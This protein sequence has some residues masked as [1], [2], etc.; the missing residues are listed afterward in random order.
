MQ[1]FPGATLGNMTQDVRNLPDALSQSCDRLP[2]SLFLC[3]G[4]GSI[5]DVNET[6]CR[7]L[8]FSRADLRRLGV[9]DLD[10]RFSRA[11]WAELSRTVRPG[12]S[13]RFGAVLRGRG[14]VTTKV[15]LSMT[16]LE[17]GGKV[18]YLLMADHRAPAQE[19][20]LFS[21]MDAARSDGERGGRYCSWAVDLFSKEEYWSD[22]SY[23]I[24]DVDPQASRLSLEGFCSLL[25]AENQAVLR[26]ALDQSLEAR[27]QRQEF[28]F[29]VT[30]RNGELR[31]LTCSLSTVRGLSGQ[32]FKV[33]GTIRDVTA[34]KE[35]ENKL[36]LAKRSAD[37]ANAAKSSF[38]AH[39]CHEIKTPVAAICGYIE[40]LGDEPALPVAV[41]Q[42]L[43]TI[44]NNADH[45]LTIANN[46]LDIS[47]I[48]ANKFEADVRPVAITRVIER[49]TSMVVLHARQ[50]NLSFHVDYALPIPASIH[51]DPSLLTHVLTNVL[52]NAV[53]Y[54]EKGFVTLRV[55]FIQ[56][57][58]PRFLFAVSDSGCGV[59]SEEQSH[60][61]EPYRRFVS[62]EAAYREGAGLGLSVAKRMLQFLG[63][64]IHVE[65]KVGEGSTFTVE[66]PQPQ[67]DLGLLMDA[68]APED[69]RQPRGKSALDGGLNRLR[70]LLA[71]DTKD[72]QELYRI[73]FMRAGIDVEIVENGRQCID[74]ALFSK[75]QGRPFDL[76]LMDVNMPVCNG[77]AATRALREK[78]WTG[79]IVA[80]TANAISEDV[81]ASYAVAGYDDCISKSVSSHELL[82]MI[83]Q[84][85]RSRRFR[86]GAAMPASS[87]ELTGRADA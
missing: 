59:S 58:A 87:A 74:R 52:N 76:I 22:E 72:I 78:G 13:R 40:L 21:I 79:P 47:K 35:L 30:W 24:L 55:G 84:C 2:M 49:A 70:L 83:D 8:D 29:N 62:P 68:I 19:H 17:Q 56:G 66:L 9:C 12:E 25:D 71:E 43:R 81:V 73:V 42:R 65:S 7:N 36:R 60:L 6:A 31:H 53:K 34:H 64:D 37:V 32:A 20:R 38:I 28:D 33:T 63:G 85:C 10:V 51:T 77:L 1:L 3:D 14:G 39:I 18:R 61:F 54:T 67:G 4:D 11:G 50:K 26:A 69:R 80:I 82:R 86:P 45:L 48:E 5:V 27:I 75:V 46:L 44:Q 57:V 23:R 41:E 15:D 16:V